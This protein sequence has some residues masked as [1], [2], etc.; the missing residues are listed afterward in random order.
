MKTF[1]IILIIIAILLLIFSIIFMFLAGNLGDKISIRQS[2][3][4]YFIDTS[5]ELYGKYKKYEKLSYKLY[6]L[7]GTLAILYVLLCTIIG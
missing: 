6:Y 5:H 1:F 3:G 2:S 7:G 4:I